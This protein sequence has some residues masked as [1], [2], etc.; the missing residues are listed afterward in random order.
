MA[1]KTPHD[2]A[3][4][5]VGWVLSLA[6]T[7]F[8]LGRGWEASTLGGMTHMYDWASSLALLENDPGRAR[9][10]TFRWR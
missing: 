10:E 3:S 6:L 4:E 2:L 9:M 7:G 8:D 5:G 1:W